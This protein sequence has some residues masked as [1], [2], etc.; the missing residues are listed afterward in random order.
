[1]F[2]VTILYIIGTLAFVNIFSSVV[3]LQQYYTVVRHTY[4]STAKHYSITTPY[5]QLYLYNSFSWI[6]IIIIAGIQIIWFIYKNV[7]KKD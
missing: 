1:M 5:I 4:N 2:T 6:F 7:C 3:Y